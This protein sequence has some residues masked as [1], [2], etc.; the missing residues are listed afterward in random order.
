M[1]DIMHSVNIN[2]ARHNPPGV[3][4]LIKENGIDV[5][6]IC[7]HT[8]LVFLKY[9]SGIASYQFHIHELVGSYQI[10]QDL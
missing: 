10:D 3:V 4:H 5:R 7:S 2:I 9:T 8:I 6:Y 1:G